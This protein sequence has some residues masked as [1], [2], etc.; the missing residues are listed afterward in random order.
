MEQAAEELDPEGPMLTHPV[1]YSEPSG[2][3]E[4]LY[5]RSFEFYFLFHFIKMYRSLFFIPFCRE[6]DGDLRLDVSP[7]SQRMN[8]FIRPAPEERRGV[9]GCS[10]PF[11]EKERDGLRGG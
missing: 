9:T 5:N 3:P 10:I 7:I 2:T 4:V 8:L 11:E 1:F 6:E